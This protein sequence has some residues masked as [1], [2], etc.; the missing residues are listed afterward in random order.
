M[1]LHHFI[2]HL[3]FVLPKVAHCANLHMTETLHANFRM[4][5]NM[6]TVQ[7]CVHPFSC[8]SHQK[9]T[10]MVLVLMYIVSLTHLFSEVCLLCTS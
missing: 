10:L 8:L 5:K 6:C 3:I 9:Y 1:R 4:T 7:H 2:Y